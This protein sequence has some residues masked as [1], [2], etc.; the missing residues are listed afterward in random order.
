MLFRYKNLIYLILGYIPCCKRGDQ[1][2]LFVIFCR[3]SA[4]EYVYELYTAVH[5]V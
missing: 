4:I 1:K 5:I 3:F 2:S